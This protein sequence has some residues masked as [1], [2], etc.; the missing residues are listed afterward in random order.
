MALP[1]FDPRLIDDTEN[2][3][4][5]LPPAKVAKAA[6]VQ[7][8]RGVSSLKFLLKSA[9][10]ENAEPALANF[11]TNFS[12]ETPQKPYTLAAL[13]TLAAP[14]PGKRILAAL[15]ILLIRRPDRELTVARQAVM[16][17]LENHLETARRIGWTDLELFG[18]YPVRE[19]AR[20]RYDY[21]GAVTLAAISGHSIE[22]MT[23]RAAHYENGLVYY[24]KR[25]MPVDAVPL[26]EL[27]KDC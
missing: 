16:V 1:F 26:W 21:A 11:S 3:N 25:P 18:C 24:R 5:A 17:F 23:V 8:N 2:R 13:A 9:K 6:K 20:N 7:E 19:A 22:Q 12:S 4:Q 15:P 10:V 27:G 14:L